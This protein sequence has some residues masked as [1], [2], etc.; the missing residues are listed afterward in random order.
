MPKMQIALG[1][2]TTNVRIAAMANA[3]SIERP[4]CSSIA[5]NQ[6]CSAKGAADS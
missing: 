4:V 2:W 1:D 6:A 5:R 3:S